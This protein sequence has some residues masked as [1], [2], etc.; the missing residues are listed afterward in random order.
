MSTNPYS[1]PQAELERPLDVPGVILKDIRNASVAGLISSV[2]TL[3]VTIFSIYGSPIA[4]IDAWN[5]FDVALIFGLTY[6]IYRKSRFCAV[7]M[8]IY[9]CA[10]KIYLWVETGAPNGALLAAIFFYYY[11]KGAAATFAYRRVID[12]AR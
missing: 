1:P 12:A 8:L 2:M 6:G 11:M 9:F 5:F 10:S 4:G 3:A 7:S